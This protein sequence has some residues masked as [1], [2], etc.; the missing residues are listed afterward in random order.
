[1]SILKDMLRPDRTSRRRAEQRSKAEQV[2]AEQAVKNQNEFGPNATAIAAGKKAQVLSEEGTC[3]LSSKSTAKTK[4]LRERDKK[5]TEARTVVAEMVAGVVIRG[6]PLDESAID[7]F[8]ERIKDNTVSFVTGLLEDGTL[9]LRDFTESESQVVKDL[10]ACS[11]LEPNNNLAIR[12]AG[13][14]ISEMVK[15][16]AKKAIKAE[17]RAAKVQKKMEEDIDGETPAKADAGLGEGMELY[18]SKR[19]K[20]GER[21]FMS[22]ILRETSKTLVRAEGELDMD[23]AVGE[24][25]VQFCIVET[26]NT[27]NL[28]K[29]LDN[30]VERVLAC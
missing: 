15:E 10:V 1:M 9:K 29:D 18:R 20:P 26:L 17:I 12:E 22:K 5:T 6:L 3:A 30:M 7:Q 4:R 19:I 21:T 24:A 16:K 27:M 13:D 23:R 2:L 8:G 28:V 11:F 14:Q 25:S